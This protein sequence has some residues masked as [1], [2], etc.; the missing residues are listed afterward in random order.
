MGLLMHSGDWKCTLSPLECSVVCVSCV[1][2]SGTEVPKQQ[3][4]RKHLRMHRI[5]DILPMDTE[6]L[7]ESLDKLMITMKIL[8]WVDLLG[9]TAMKRRD[10][11]HIE[12]RMMLC[13]S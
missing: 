8:K 12:R 5:M 7:N 6:D 4:R 3:K 1:H 2:V 11:I 10:C 13:F 9:T